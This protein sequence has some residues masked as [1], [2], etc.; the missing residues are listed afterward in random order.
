MRKTISKPAILGAVVAVGALMLTFAQG[1]SFAGSM[2]G[3]HG[4]KKPL[5]QMSSTDSVSLGQT[6]TPGKVMGRLM[7]PTMDPEKGKQLFVDKGCVACH[8]INGVGGHDAP[9]MDAH[10]MDK[11]MNPFDFAAKMWNHAPGM[12]AAQEEAFGE[13]INFTGSELGDIIA[14]VH[15]DESQHGFSERD[16]TP[17]ARKKMGHGHGAESAPESH[18]EEAGHGRAEGESKGHVPSPVETGSASIAD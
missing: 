1:S 18:A 14:F 7:M 5:I 11:K 6:M 12:I 8:A 4:T 10:E 9:A 13:M 15:N 2:P 3:A 16:L 17:M